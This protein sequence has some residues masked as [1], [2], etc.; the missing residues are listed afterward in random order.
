M[1]LLGTFEDMSLTDL[2]EIF[3]MGAKSGIL[4]VDQA[5]LRGTVVV[6]MG[7]LIDAEIVQHSTP[8]LQVAS[9]DNA[10]IE[11]LRWPSGDFNF[12]HDLAVL[13]HPVTIFCASEHLVELSQQP[14][15]PDAAMQPVPLAQAAQ[16]ATDIA[17][18]L[19]FRNDLRLPRRRARLAQADAA[20]EERRSSAYVHSAGL[21][22]LEQSAQEDLSTDL[23]TPRY[24]A[25]DHTFPYDSRQELAGSRQTQ[26]L[27]EPR[28]AGR[29]YASTSASNRSRLLQAVMRR[30][31]SL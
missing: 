27:A 16:P 7:R 30:V 23:A 9:G 21:T 10:V 5:A 20:P 29:A 17:L 1:T 8:P 12:A 13:R 28:M 3:R 6:S 14:A 18:E 25:C 2:I 11:M 22:W 19:E 4:T 15:D 31:R 26:S 24:E